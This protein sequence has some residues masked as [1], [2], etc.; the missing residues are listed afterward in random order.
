MKT[1]KNVLL[2]IVLVVLGIILALNSLGFANINIFFNGWWTLFIIIPSF[3]GL[4]NN[5]NKAYD[6]FGLLLGIGLL[7]A[8]NDIIDFQIVWKLV[9]PVIL[10]LIGLSF[11]FK[12]L[13][14]K[15]INLAINKLNNDDKENEYTA[16][17]SSEKINLKDQK[18]EGAKINAIFGGVDLDIRDSK[19]K[20]DQ[21]INFTAI[22]GGIDIFVPENC[23][24]VIKSNS[25]FGG[26]D[27]KANSKNEENTIY[28]NANC[29]FGGIDI[30]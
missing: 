10:I 4:F 3:I 5:S 16:T 15:K 20:G 21:L 17:F 6:I 22:F 19:I 18:F 8:S 2:G 24:V 29:L 9:V 26:V 23:K 30:K 13:F 11:M 12:D 27:N 7:L 28:I 1:F 14:N 25:I